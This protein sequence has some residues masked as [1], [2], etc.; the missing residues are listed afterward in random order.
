M[1]CGL[2][3]LETD[4]SILWDKE[5]RVEIK[6][7]ADHQTEN[8][9]MEYIGPDNRPIWE[10]HCR[11]RFAEN[12]SFSLLDVG[13]GDGLFVDSMLASYPH[14]TATVLDNSELLLGRNK[15]NARKQLVCGSAGD[16]A[17]LFPDQKFDLISFHW[18]LH[19]F[20]TDSHRETTRTVEAILATA[21]RLLKPNGRISVWENMYDGWLFDR[22]PGKIIFALSSSKLLVPL[23]RK[24]GA[25][26][27]GVGVCFRSFREWRQLLETSGLE[28]VAYGD[29]KDWQ[30]RLIYK[31]A[32]H[33]GRVRTGHFWMRSW[34]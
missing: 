4:A 2:R 19:H 30:F 26:T 32:L 21:R 10:K 15:P 24:M 5:H 16:L 29:G 20:V 27:A 1:Q 7:L 34:A 23:T 28:Q 13:G 14:L 18:V 17:T 12:E 6:R 25:N 33:M 31:L 9:D 3:N 11:E 22:L 8:F